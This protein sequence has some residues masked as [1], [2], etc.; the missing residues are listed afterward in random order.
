MVERFGEGLT[1]IPSRSITPWR[2]LRERF[3]LEPGPST[4]VP[5]VGKTIVPVTSI[6]DALLYHKGET[7]VLDLTVS[8]GTFVVASTVPEGKRWHIKFVM[9]AAVTVG[10][11][12]LI[13]IFGLNMQL[14]NQSTAAQ[15]QHEAHFSMEA[16]DKIGMRANADANDD[17]ILFNILFAEETLSQLP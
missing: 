4:F 8:A 14:H 17:A 2:R 11:W 16:G 15:F 12:T 7:S 1:T 6:D 5:D 13:Q 10:T 9:H 3:S